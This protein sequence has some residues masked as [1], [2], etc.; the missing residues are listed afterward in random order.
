MGVLFKYFTQI[1]YDHANQ[2]YKT[3]LNVEK[4]IFQL[5]IARYYGK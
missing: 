3:L 5:E 1:G 2:M 4:F